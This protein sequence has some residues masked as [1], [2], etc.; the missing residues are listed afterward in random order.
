[1]MIVRLLLVLGCVV[2]VYLIHRANE[3]DKLI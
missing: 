2:F 1:M 3:R